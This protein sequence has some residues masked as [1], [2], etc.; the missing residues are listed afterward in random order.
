MSPPHQFKAQHAFQR[1][2][3]MGSMAALADILHA[4]T[5]VHQQRGILGGAGLQGFRPERLQSL[6][7]SIEG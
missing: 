6:G 5:D 2:P 3:R 4:R 1:I 7:K